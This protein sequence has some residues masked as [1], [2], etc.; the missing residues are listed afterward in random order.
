MI[1][2]HAGILADVF[3]YEMRNH[4]NYLELG[5]F[6]VMPNH[7]HGILILNKDD[8][9]TDN[10]VGTTH[11]LSLTPK[12][13]GQQRFQN[14]GKNSVSSIIGGYKS[15]VTKHAKRLGLDFTCPPRFTTTLFITKNHTKPFPITSST[16]H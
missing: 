10:P 8:G 7:V 1:F 2:S 16:I 3:W 11:A 14:Q 13:I 4:A 12:T 15:A 5:E 9:Q 6:V